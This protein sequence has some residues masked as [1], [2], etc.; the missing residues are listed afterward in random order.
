[1]IDEDNLFRDIKDKMTV[2]KYLKFILKRS[3][4]LKIQYKLR[5][6]I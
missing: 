4:P 5:R 6:L 1:M 3:V 2:K